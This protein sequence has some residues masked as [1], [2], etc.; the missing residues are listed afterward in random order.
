MIKLMVKRGKRIEYIDVARALGMIAIIIGRVGFSTWPVA[1]RIMFSFHLPIF[2]IISGLLARKYPWRELIKKRLKS[3]IVPYLITSAVIIA[4]VF[5]LR[6]TG[7][8]FWGAPVHSTWSWVLSALYG[9]GYNYEFGIQPIGAIW[10]LLAMFF[11]SLF[12]N[13]II[14]KKYRF[15]YAGLA[16]LAAYMIAPHFWAP[17][18][19][20]S[21]IAG[22]FYMLIGVKMKEIGLN[23]L[24]KWPIVLGSFIVWLCVLLISIKTSDY[25]SI[26]RLSFSILPLDIVAAIAGSFCVLVVA[27]LIEKYLRPVAN[28]LKPFGE[29]SLIVLCVHLID[30]CFIDWHAIIRFLGFNFGINGLGVLRLVGQFIWCICW[31]LIFRVVRNRQKVRAAFAVKE[32]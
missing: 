32:K 27:K 10:F 21:A 18:S 2:F 25:F 17:W 22:T 3:L 4:L 23:R 9:S 24:M 1:V 8:N 26:V 30:L 19:I 11:A 31:V 7:A 28:V 13:L 14:D 29:Y 16:M 5:V 6:H 12:L 20:L 15:I